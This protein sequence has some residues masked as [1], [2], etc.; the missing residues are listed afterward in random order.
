MAKEGDWMNLK[1]ILDAGSVV[2]YHST[3]IDKKQFNSE[4]QWE[5]GIILKKIYPECSA[6]LL[7]HSLM[8]LFLFSSLSVSL[9]L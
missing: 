8:V 5:V 9:V 2:R 3:L 1:K 6:D 4:H 7:F